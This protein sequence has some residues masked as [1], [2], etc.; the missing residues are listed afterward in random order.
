MLLIPSIYK[1]ESTMKKQKQKKP[2]KLPDAT[3]S[4]ISENE[5]E[6]RERQINK[7]LDQ[8]MSMLIMEVGS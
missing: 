4:D 7:Q 3:Q 6:E 2:L 5:L 1:F 8:E